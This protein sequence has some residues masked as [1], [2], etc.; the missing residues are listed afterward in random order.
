MPPGTGEEGQAASPAPVRRTRSTDEGDS[1]A[2]PVDLLSG[3][4][5]AP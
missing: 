1:T 3:L 5:A 2:A 4:P